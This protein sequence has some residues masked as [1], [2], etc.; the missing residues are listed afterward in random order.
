[1]CVASIIGALACVDDPFP[2]PAPPKVVAAS[3][4]LFADAVDV[5]TT[6]TSTPAPVPVEHVDDDAFVPTSTGATSVQECD[7]VLAA[8]VRVLGCIN[9]QDP[10]LKQQMQQ[11]IDAMKLGVDGLD[12]QSQQ[13]RERARRSCKMLYDAFEP[14][15]VQ[16]GCGVR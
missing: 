2:P 13:A 15:A 3:R 5:A 8:Y 6:T 10:Q 4:P 1:M 7:D 16:M 9:L 11:A 14:G 12:H